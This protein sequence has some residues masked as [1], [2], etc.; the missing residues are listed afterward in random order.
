[1][2]SSRVGSS[3][4]TPVKS[5]QV[6]P[7]LPKLNSSLFEG[8]KVES[9]LF[10]NN[11]SENAEELK[12][13]QTP[14]NSP[15]NSQTPKNGKMIDMNKATFTSD[16]LSDAKGAAVLDISPKGKNNAFAFRTNKEPG[17][18]LLNMGS[19]HRR[20]NSDTVATPLASKM[21]MDVI[22]E[23]FE[24][25]SA[26]DS[27]L[28]KS[29]DEKAYRSVIDE[30]HN[31]LMDV[32]RTSP[33]P[34]EIKISLPKPCGE[35]GQWELRKEPLTSDQ[36]KDV[37]KAMYANGMQWNKCVAAYANG[38]MAQRQLLSDIRAYQLEITSGLRSSIGLS[39]DQMIACGSVSLASDCDF[40]CTAKEKQDLHVRLMLDGLRE[41]FGMEPGIVFD[42]NIYSAHIALQTNFNVN[43]QKEIAS[44]TSVHQLWVD[45]NDVQAK[46]KQAQYYQQIDETPSLKFENSLF[47]KELAQPRAETQRVLVLEKTGDTRAANQAYET[48]LRNF[49]KAFV[50][51]NVTNYK[52][53]KEVEKITKSSQEALDL[54]KAQGKADSPEAT[55]LSIKLNTPGAIEME[56][57]NKLYSNLLVQVEEKK[58]LF[59]EKS[60]ELSLAVQDMVNE[61][62]I[63]KED[64]H[65][66]L[67]KGCPENDVPSGLNK[68]RALYMSELNRNIQELGVQTMALQSEALHYASE[69]Y[70][71]QATIVGIVGGLQMPVGHM[72]KIL[73]DPNSGL[74]PGIQDK[75]KSLKLNLAPFVKDMLL[76]EKL[77]GKNMEKLENF[78]SEEMKI[79]QDKLKSAAKETEDKI[80]QDYPL[81]ALSETYD[82]TMQENF[83]DFVKD[84]GHY[85]VH[86]DHPQ[87]MKFIVKSS[88]YLFRTAL[89]G[90]KYLEKTDRADTPLGKVMSRLNEEAYAILDVRQESTGNK[91]NDAQIVKDAMVNFLNFATTT[92]PELKSLMDPKDLNTST[93]RV[94]QRLMTLT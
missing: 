40:T 44:G 9:T 29:V 82:M 58:A 50:I 63:S 37:L 4:Q 1:M 11:Q 3:S 84:Y 26:Q 14:N 83:G 20:T 49:K 5:A 45:Q 71:A 73:Q 55:L 25:L 62:K 81:S 60:S 53:E 24:Q 19:F 94:A 69:P 48:E 65:T 17:A 38:T 59:D 47:Y 12:N 30:H 15:K 6:K 32:I 68:E 13:S 39:K 66:W 78:S 41:M 74:P 77:T 72:V 21:P 8:S 91:E 56:A 88:K 10:Q 76:I 31:L 18:Y 89:S 46:V 85:V 90:K 57:K 79:F 87:D 16:I 61:G 27:G 34:K 70:Y 86:S 64:L 54:L 35:N 67:S 75:L 36:K 2:S 33:N 7:A 92:M 51:N 52:V 23:T 43:S 28:S 80:K 93:Y 22:E 42:T